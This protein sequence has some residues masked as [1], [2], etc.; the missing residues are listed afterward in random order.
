LM[1]IHF[2]DHVILGDCQYYSYR[3]QGRI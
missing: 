3:E 2:A 1:R